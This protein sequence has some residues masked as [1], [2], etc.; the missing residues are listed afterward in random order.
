[1]TLESLMR[2][3]NNNAIT[4][5]A[6]GGGNPGRKAINIYQG[7]DVNTMAVCI[8]AYSPYSGDAN[9]FLQ[10][11][12]PNAYNQSGAS[13]AFKKGN[14]SGY[15]LTFEALTDPA[16]PTGANRLGQIRAYTAPFA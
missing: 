13:V 15:T 3:F 8:R 16:N 12:L 5:N 11:E 9:S 6:N 14:A 2:A 4:A 1:M 10:I 7:A